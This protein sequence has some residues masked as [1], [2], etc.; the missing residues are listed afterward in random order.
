M[1]FQPYLCQDKASQFLVGFFVV[2]IFLLDPAGFQ[3]RRRS[4][5]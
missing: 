3:P 2:L 5:P 4:C 1:D